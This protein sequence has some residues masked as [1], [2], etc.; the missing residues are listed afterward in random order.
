MDTNTVHS[1]GDSSTWH[2]WRD[3]ALLVS[4][5]PLLWGLR[6]ADWVDKGA[7]VLLILGMALLRL[8][9]RRR[10]LSNDQLAY[11][12]A[13]WFTTLDALDK[14]GGY[15][16]GEGWE[17]ASLGTGALIFIYLTRHALSSPRLV[18][19]TP[20][21]LLFVPL[22]QVPLDLT[23]NLI[24]RSVG[25]PV[26]GLFVTKMNSEGTF[27]V[28]FNKSKK[29]RFIFRTEAGEAIVYDTDTTGLGSGSMPPQYSRASVW[30]RN[31]VRLVVLE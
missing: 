17:L 22:G 9:W 4:L 13:F 3:G 31:L 2:F 29:V 25:L 6:H 30:Q 10:P 19:A 11:Y 23:R 18:V 24:A 15:G 21:L 7:I 1:T 26:N 8:V 20:L 12:L 14:F 5:V 16:E 27:G 28:F